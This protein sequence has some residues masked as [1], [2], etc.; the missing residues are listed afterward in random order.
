[1]SNTPMWISLYDKL[2]L[3]RPRLVVLV[4]LLVCGCLAC[5]IK[6]FRLDASADSL[7]LEHDEDLKYFRGINERYGTG[8]FLLV[9]YA[10]KG[11]LFS[12][13]ALAGL[14]TLRDQ[15]SRLD[16]V[17]SV[18]TILD[19]PLLRNPPAPLKDLK[20]N[21]KTLESPDV[22]KTLAKA[23]LAQSPIFRNLLVS[24]DM[25]STALQVNLERDETYYDLLKRR[26]QLRDKEH[27]GTLTPEGRAELD[28][29]SAQY[30]LHKR[31]MDRDRHQD[32]RAVRQVM[33]RSRAAAELFL[34]GL[35]MIADDMVSFIRNDLKVF[36]FGMLVFLII[37]LGVIFRR[38]RW[39]LL[40]M[41]CCAFSTVVMM[42]MLGVSGWEVTVISSN[43]VS[44]QLIMTMSLT[45]HL[46]VR[47]TE[48]LAEQPEA[49]NERL[50]SETVRTIFKPCLYTTLTTIAGFSS[51]MFCEILPVINFGWMMTVGL[52]ISLLATF[53]LFPAGLVLM[54]KVT[55]RAGK[56]FGASL[57]A[58]FARL[59]EK[60]GPAIVACSVAVVVV[61]VAGILRLEVEN[62]FIDYFRDS[63]EIYRGMEFIDREMGG[64]TP[65]DVI[66]DFEG[67]VP[68]APAPEGGADQA[69]E[70][71]EFGEFDEA[72]SDAKYWFTPEKMAVIAKVHDYLDDL[73]ETGKVL[74]LNTMIRVADQLTDGKALDGFNLA[75][76]F[77][78]LPDEFKG[79]VLDPFVSI[80]HNQVRIW[81]RIKDSME[82]LRRDAFLKR[83]RADLVG[84]LGLKPEQV[85]LTGM[86]VLY[87]NMLQSL[88][89]SQ[90]RT[91]GVTV[92]A[93]M[94][95]FMVLFRSVKV[96]LIAIFPN[97]LS[98]LV[99]LGVMGLFSIPLD[100][101]TIT[102]VAI[103]VGIAV[104]DTIHYIHRFKHEFE[105][106]RNYMNT[107]FRCHGSIGAAM[108]YTSITIT[109]GFSILALSNFIPS[110]LFGLLTGLAMAMA[111]VAAL[112]LLPRLI[113]LFKPFGPE[114][115]PE[116]Q[117]A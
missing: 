115:E 89:R 114:G 52:V 83:I 40:P 67:A 91:I 32:I 2:V 22:D 3:R 36:G 97:L 108:Y 109:I 19:V 48:L 16:R 96:S 14:G 26:A 72:E 81:V 49:D 70:F 75:L 77:N 21:I 86:M 33:D 102:I 85:R 46:I 60:R 25:Q 53:L 58:S 93:L 98:A 113:I 80:E 73:P 54:R 50:I 18:V 57:T 64:T 65:L 38:K 27:E 74:S 69:D 51:L 30:A 35:P 23:E 44:L 39:I 82:T 79:I 1:M 88:F 55:P 106:D 28:E 99:V 5:R 95:M 105:Q 117:S 9:T 6:D 29:V 62:S 59:T 31:Q 76:L 100:M 24:P 66:I 71:D 107:M 11:G 116:Q 12:D 8:D 4:L 43:F 47:Y 10:P 84:K 92:L 42:G 20:A 45:I 90:I 103:S 112:T 111:L 87:N 61:T 13:Q 56:Q 94:L 68:E 78:E 15:L 104:D 41:L 101:M 17:S 110:V 7:V 63:T 37:T 34:G